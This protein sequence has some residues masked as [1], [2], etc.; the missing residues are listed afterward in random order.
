M[1]KKEIGKI[2]HFFSK[3]NVAVVM[4]SGS[5][6]VGDNILIER[7]DGSTFEQS[8]NSMQIDRNEIK[9]ASS[10]QDIGMKVK[11]EVKEGNTVY[12]LIE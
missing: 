12:K 8:V 1:E 5:L 11:E 10:G 2:T 6:D 9:N 3:L 4:L 7:S